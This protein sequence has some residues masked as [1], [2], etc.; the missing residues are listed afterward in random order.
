MHVD[1][2]TVLSENMVFDEDLFSREKNV[3][4][5]AFFRTCQRFNR[6]TNFVDLWYKLTDHF[7]ATQAY[8][9]TR[10]F[11]PGPA[12]LWRRSKFI[13]VF[14][15]HPSLPF[16]EDI[17]GGFTTLNK[18]YAI[19]SETRCMVTTFAPPV[20]FATGF[21]AGRIQG[22]L[23]KPIGYLLQNNILHMIFD[24]NDSI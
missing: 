6:V 20:L 7:H 3:I 12:G 17:F 13:E 16:G 14:G 10:S 2:D 1:D 9:A 8:I 19:R 22:I 24:N 21:T 5:L 23:I 4:A 15:A 18:G 11:V